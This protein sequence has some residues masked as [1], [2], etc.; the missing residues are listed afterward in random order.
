MRL[1]FDNVYTG[2]CKKIEFYESQIF[3][4]KALMKNGDH[5]WS[6]AILYL[7]GSDGID[8]RINNF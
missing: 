6:S 7:I 2:T 5:F 4:L 8:E 1:V 3:Y